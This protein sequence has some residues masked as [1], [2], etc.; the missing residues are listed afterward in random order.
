M[1]YQP[2]VSSDTGKLDAFEALLRWRSP[3]AGL[4]VPAD[5]LP[6]LES[7]GLMGRAGEWM[8]Q[9]I[10]AQSERWTERTGRTVPITINLSAEQ[11]RSES[12]IKSLA[13]AVASSDDIALLV[14]VREEEILKNRDTLIPVLEQLRERGVRVVFEGIGTSVCC[15]DYLSMLPVDAIKLDAG[16]AD[17][18]A[19]YSSQHTVVQQIVAHA[20]KLGLD[21][22]GTRIERP[23]QMSEALAV[24]DAMQGFMVSRPVDA[25][26]ATAMLECDWKVALN[27]IEAEEMY[28]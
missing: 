6:S 11:L 24:C 28:S 8:V 26:T 7:A 25:E 23:D 3:M 5:F 22:I 9:A 4:Q 17:S 18:V 2:I 27:G 1:H 12:L 19:R 10:V 20:H 13:A 16:F 15:L 14:E 21:V